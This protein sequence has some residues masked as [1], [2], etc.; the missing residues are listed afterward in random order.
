MNDT[1][2]LILFD[3]DATLLKTNA[4]GIRAMEHAGLELYERD[5]NASGI[6]YAGRL[7]PLILIDILV[8][9]S[10]DPTPEELARFRDG[11]H[12]HLKRLFEEFPDSSYA[13]P[14]VQDLLEALR[15]HASTTLGVLTGN[16][17]ETGTMKITR[18]GIDMDHFEILVWGDDS[19][20]D[21]PARE[22]LP[23]VAIEKHEA[24]TGSRPD[25]SRVLII[26][27]TIHDVSC[28]HAHDCICL[29]VATGLYSH[30]DLRDAGAHHVVED[31]S[32]TEAIMAW[33]RLAATTTQ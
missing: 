12:R 11:Y 17:P 27:D 6:N 16:F 19:P 26:G 23:G 22:H 20:H 31:L 5:M 33:M 28:A 14:G 9:N 2:Q 24:H 8:E 29:G 10:I 1:P 32:N 25:P 13:L 3:I 4:L 21:K 15:A 30:D 7:D 18:A